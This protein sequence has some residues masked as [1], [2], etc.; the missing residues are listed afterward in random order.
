MID[1]AHP[2]RLSADPCE[3][4]CPLDHLPWRSLQG[5][6]ERSRVDGRR[7]EPDEVHSVRGP[8]SF[9][10][11]TALDIAMAI[12]VLFRKADHGPWTTDKRHFRLQPGVPDYN[13]SGR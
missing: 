5:K 4:V 8:S 13:V 10:R 9:V 12:A 6:V 1:A 11:N 3:P 2:W 7:W